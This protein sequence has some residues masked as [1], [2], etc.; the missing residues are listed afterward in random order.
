[1]SGIL[2]R[3]ANDLPVETPTPFVSGAPRVAPTRFIVRTLYRGLGRG[4]V[5]GKDVA[6]E[7]RR[8][9]YL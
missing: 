3:G 5:P 4:R 2:Y 9:D 7:V 8:E 6:V 1:M